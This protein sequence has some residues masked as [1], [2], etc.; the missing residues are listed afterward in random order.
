I[1]AKAED[2]VAWDVLVKPERAVIRGRGVERCQQ[3]IRRIVSGAVRIKDNACGIRWTAEWDDIFHRPGRKFCD[4]R[5]GLAEGPACLLICQGPDCRKDGAS[6]TGAAYRACLSADHGDGPGV[7]VGEGGNIR[8]LPVR[9]GE[10]LLPV[11]LGDEAAYATTGAGC[12][13]ME[14]GWVENTITI[15]DHNS[16]V[17]PGD[18]CPMA[19]SI[20]DADGCSTNCGDIL[21]A[22][23]KIRPA[24]R[25]RP[26]PHIT[27][28]TAG[29]IYRDALGR[30]SFERLIET[31]E[32]M[33]SPGHLRVSIA[34][35]DDVA[36][37]VFLRILNGVLKL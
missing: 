9:S 22:G 37:L 36:E 34:V 26:G 16:I 10:G 2:D 32:S 14:D 29:E 23:R 28:V 31:L 21:G 30:C 20:G 33:C 6:Q 18:L 3:S 35:G 5:G 12:E 27:V 11:R 19:A 4:Q 24:P 17:P 25:G 7:W 13:A 15:G 1:C 8:Y